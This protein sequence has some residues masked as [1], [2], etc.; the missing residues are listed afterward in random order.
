MEQESAAAADLLRLLAFLDP[1][2][3][4]EEIMTLSAAE[5]GLAL[6]MVASDPL[7]VDTIFELLLRYSLIRRNPEV[8]FLSI[9]RLVQA[10][11][12]HAINTETQPLYPYRTIR[13]VTT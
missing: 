10:V 9:H 1:E 13:P 5:L 7:E 3:I 4:P 8:K 12:K 2:A 11:L 6:G